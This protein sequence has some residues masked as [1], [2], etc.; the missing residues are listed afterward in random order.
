LSILNGLDVIQL[1]VFGWDFPTGAKFWGFLGKMTPKRQMREKHLLEGHFLM[2][3]ATF[4]PLCVKLSLSV[5][6]VQVRKKKKAVRKEGRKVIRSVY[7]TYV[8]SDP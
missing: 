3:T 5:W 6:T 7:F 2:Q 1:F 4:E 8:W